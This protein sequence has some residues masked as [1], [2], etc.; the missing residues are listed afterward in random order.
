MGVPVVLLH[1]DG[2]DTKA[3]KLEHLHRPC[4]KRQFRGAQGAL[5]LICHV[6]LKT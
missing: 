1:V 2:G 4:I 6:V 5:I 3:L